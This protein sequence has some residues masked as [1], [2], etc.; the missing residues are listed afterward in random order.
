MSLVLHP[1]TE[2]AV[3]AVRPLLPPLASWGN[4][5]VLV[6][7]AY[8]CALLALVAAALVALR[9]LRRSEASEVWW[10][11]AR[12]AHAARVVAA[13]GLIVMPLALGALATATIG[14]LSKVPAH[15]LEALVALAALVPGV[16]V[17]SYIESVVCQRPIGPFQWLRVRLFAGL[18]VAPHVFLPAV[19]AFIASYALVEQSFL[20]AIGVAFAGVV[21][22]VTGVGWL[23]ARALGW[24]CTAP[25]RVHRLMTTA[26]LRAGVPAPRNVYEFRLAN[27]NAYAL[28]RGIA[29]STGAL[30]VLS[31]DELVAVLLHE[32]AHIAEP[33]R[34]RRLRFFA[35]ALLALAIF[36][37][38]PIALGLKTPAF[39]FCGGWLVLVAARWARRV[40]RRL[41]AAA[42]ASAAALED[43][44]VYAR[45]LERL[46]VVNLVPAV[47][48]Q[49]TTHPDLYDRMLAVGVQPSFA[50]PAPP[51]T[52]RA[53][54]A[55]WLALGSIVTLGVALRAGVYAQS[56]DAPSEDSIAT[57]ISFCGGGALAF[58]RLAKVR[59][60]R[61]EFDDAMVL[62]RAAAALEPSDDF[63]PA[64]T[65]SVFGDAGRCDDAERRLEIAQKFDKRVGGEWSVVVRDARNDVRACLERRRA[66]NAGMEK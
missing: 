24:V 26:A 28:R 65:A 44:A 6:P 41:E 38:V 11:R 17:A 27:A 39:V 4:V 15:R 37:P 58:A 63:V 19:A 10:E 18:V 50:R 66:S 2:R 52:T 13:L 57:E 61:G 20:L 55:F 7:A 40:E 43:T 48:G 62:L 8:S 21:A 45:A 34:V 23:V 3:E 32:L 36:A 46:H 5:I 12:H 56:F 49:A 16:C 1:E 60:A 33:P 29:F 53:Q 31:D 54:G 51:D 9:P 47:L 22:G 42:D 14:P 25:S 30:D 35:R 64:T 59:A